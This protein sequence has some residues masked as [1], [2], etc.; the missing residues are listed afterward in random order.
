MRI[1]GSRGAQH[2]R[3]ALVVDDDVVVQASHA[4]PAEISRAAMVAVDVVVIDLRS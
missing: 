4:F 1:V 2:R 3:V